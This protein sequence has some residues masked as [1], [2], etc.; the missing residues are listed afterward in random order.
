MFRQTLLAKHG[1]LVFIPQHK[2]SSSGVAELAAYL[3]QELE[4]VVEA[5]W[6]PIAAEGV[7]TSLHMFP[8]C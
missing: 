1:K 5:L 2:L 7:V 8:P 3:Q 4:A 6:R